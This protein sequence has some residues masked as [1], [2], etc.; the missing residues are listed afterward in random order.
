MFTGIIEEIG[1]VSSLET[2][3]DA[4]RLILSIR[5]VSGKLKMGDS[6][7]VNGICLTITRYSSTM[8]EAD[9]SPETLAKTNLK[10]LKSGDICNLERAIRAGEPLGGHFVTGHIDGTGEILTVITKGNSYLIK[11]SAPGKLMKYIAS[12]GS[13]AVDG[14]SL[15]PINCTDKTFDIAVIPHT[16]HHT[17]LYKRPAGSIVNI[18]CDIL[19]KYMERLM[20]FEADT[21]IEEKKGKIDR[22]FLKK[23]GFLI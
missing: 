22:D 21:A 9:V 6:L 4:T 20:Y 5:K 19:C 8:C 13:V 1:T 15:T 18:E 3:T 12:K 23:T 10:G 14:I 7:A 11:I 16:Y 2:S 17:T